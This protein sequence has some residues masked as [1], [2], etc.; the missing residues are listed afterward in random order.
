MQFTQIDGPRMNRHVGRTQTRLQFL[1]AGVPAV[2]TVEPTTYR[3]GSE[4]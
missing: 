2:G 3:D 1:R 4:A